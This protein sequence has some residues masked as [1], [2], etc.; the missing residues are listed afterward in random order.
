MARGPPT[1]AATAAVIDLTRSPLKV[2]RNYKHTGRRIKST[3][4]NY[5][6]IIIF[7]LKINNTTAAQA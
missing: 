1:V 7:V 3:F 6:V 5:F 4:D 2:N